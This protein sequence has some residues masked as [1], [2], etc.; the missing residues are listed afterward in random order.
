MTD[1]HGYYIGVKDIHDLV[2]KLDQ[3]IDEHL[4]AQAVAQ[5]RL[6]LKVERLEAAQARGWQ[7]WL[8]VISAGLALATAIIVPLVTR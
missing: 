2:V 3:K 7:V 1:P 4:G 5:A 6:E 8:A